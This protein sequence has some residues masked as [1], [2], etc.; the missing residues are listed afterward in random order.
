MNVVAMM[1]GLRVEAHIGMFV[2]RGT[3]MF[4]RI[5]AFVRT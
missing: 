5:Q 3:R 4:C 2:I 1:L